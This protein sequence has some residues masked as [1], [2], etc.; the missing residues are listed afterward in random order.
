MKIDHYNIVAPLIARREVLLHHHAGIESFSHQLF[1]SG[2]QR[3]DIKD[4]LKFTADYQP[5]A[6]VRVK[7]DEQIDAFHLALLHARTAILA[8]IDAELGL[9]KTQLTALGVEI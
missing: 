4:F 9:I 5:V 7:M 1:V 3:T 2:P 8:A 6:K